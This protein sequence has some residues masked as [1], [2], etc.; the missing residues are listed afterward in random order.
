M[1]ILQILLISFFVSV[2]SFG[3]SRLML[4]KDAAAINV[5]TFGVTGNGTTN[6]APLLQSLVGS[7]KSLFLPKGTYKLNTRIQFLNISNLKIIAEKGTVIT[8]AGNGGY[9]APNTIFEFN[10][11]TSNI[12]VS[13]VEFRCTNISTTEDANA[14]V[15]LNNAFGS[16]LTVDNFYLHDCKIIAP[17]SNT[18]GFV[19]NTGTSPATANNILAERV[20]IDSVGRMGMEFM[21]NGTTAIRQT[22]IKIRDCNISHTGLNGTW[23]VGISCTGAIKDADI[24]QNY[25][26]E[27]GKD[28]AIEFNQTSDVTCR[29]NRFTN[30]TATASGISVSN[31]NGSLTPSNIL[32]QGNILNI[33]DA[34]NTSTQGFSCLNVRNLKITDN[35]ITTDSYNELNNCDSAV[36][37]GNTINAKGYYA[38]RIY[39]TTRGALISNNNINS[40]SS[41]T[42]GGTIYSGVVSMSD[43]GTTA[44]LIKDNNISS[45]DG[46]FLFV[47]SSGATGNI[48]L[49]PSGSATY[50]T[51]TLQANPN[52]GTF[53][54]A[55]LGTYYWGNM[56]WGLTPPGTTAGQRAGVIPVNCTLVGYAITTLP[57]N[58]GTTA[59]ASSIYVRKAN[60]TDILLTNALTFASTATSTHFTGMN[61]NT[62]FNAN[63]TFENKLV[64]ANWGTAPTGVQIHVTLIFKPR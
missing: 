15:Y 24:S 45:P 25:F 2:S 17:N 36:I 46:Q 10:G 23:G 4:V 59:E 41:T 9:Y 60:S 8:F 20:T 53:S 39:G 12:E 58:A 34:T 38:L 14:V 3:Q 55:K 18:N 62:D 13:G 54:P 57:G 22:A 64:C 47:E 61:L 19:V 42:N 28:E 7:N 52:A 31:G 37:K 16:G 49:A 1:K 51:L 21:N 56:Y 29:G 6:D 63:E 43:A 30:V 5:R 50:F 11:T 27:I 44:N 32:L 40:I 33:H 26:S 35:S 48:Y